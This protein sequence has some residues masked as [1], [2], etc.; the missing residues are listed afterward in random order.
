M[1]HF[2]DIYKTITRHYQAKLLY[3]YTTQR[4]IR[5]SKNIRICSKHLCHVIFYYNYD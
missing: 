2:K 5:A 3:T 4:Y 1:V